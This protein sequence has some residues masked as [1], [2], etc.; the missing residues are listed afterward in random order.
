M[1]SQFPDIK[2]ILFLSFGMIVDSFVFFSYGMS[3]SGVQNQCCA[4]IPKSKTDVDQNRE[5]R[6]IITWKAQE[7][8]GTETQ[9]GSPDWSEPR[10][11][12]SF[13]RLRESCRRI[14]KISLI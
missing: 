6:R 3:V 7:Q 11:G 8:R 12:Q 5:S 14:T 9:N 1:G 10:G 13:R 2:S 4:W